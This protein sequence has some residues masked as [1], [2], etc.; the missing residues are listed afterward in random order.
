[1]TLIALKL[2]V[3]KYF[4]FHFSSGRFSQSLISELKKSVLISVLYFIVSNWFW[5]KNKLG[6]YLRRVI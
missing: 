1:M 4:A 3:N 6:E 2:L 5:V